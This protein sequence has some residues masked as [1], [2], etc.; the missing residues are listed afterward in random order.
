MGFIPSSLPA[1]ITSKAC[2]GVLIAGGNE[3]LLR[4]LS[5][6]ARA[7][8]NPCGEKIVS[9]EFGS[10]F[11]NLL[12]V[13]NLFYNCDYFKRF[14][15]KIEILSGVNRNLIDIKDVVKIVDNILKYEKKAKIINI[16]NF[17]SNKVLDIVLY[18][19]RIYSIK[20]N[21]QMKK[22]PVSFNYKININDIK[23]YITLSKIKFSKSYY[24]KVI[25]KYYGK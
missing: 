2:S 4:S 16:A 12:S 3:L 7:W 17:Y 25:N 15:K 6:T 8:S 24:K 19:G 11:I 10:R 1:W 23:K 20:S 9:G 5:Q 22:N 18:L 21:L 14:N 13:I